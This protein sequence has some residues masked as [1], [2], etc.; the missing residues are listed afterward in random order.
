M[1]RTEPENSLSTSEPQCSIDAQPWIEHSR[2]GIRRCTSGS[3]TKP[4]PR[5]QVSG[6]Q[7]RHSSI[8]VQESRAPEF[9]TPPRLNSGRGV[10]HFKDPI[11]RATGREAGPVDR[12]QKTLRVHCFHHI[13]APTTLLQGRSRVPF[14]I[15]ATSESHD[16]MSLAM[17]QV[18]THPTPAPGRAHA[19]EPQEKPSTQVSLSNVGD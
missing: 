3:G 7:D 10:N 12:S 5:R 8:D 13:N 15:F 9:Q 17:T 16:G 18:H 11:R 1:D 6:S 14:R 4:R 19:P 2:S